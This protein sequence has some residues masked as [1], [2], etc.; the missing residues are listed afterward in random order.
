MSSFKKIIVAVA[1]S[2]LSVGSFGAA[3]AET[4]KPLRGICF[5]SD[6]KDVVAS[7]TADKGVCNVVL[8]LTDKIAYATTRFE[9]QVDVRKSTLHQVDDG[10]ALEFARQAHAQATSINMLAAVATG[11]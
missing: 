11:H 6:I 1:L 10:K 3:Q 5:H 2:A 7:F 4:V 8:T 9:Q